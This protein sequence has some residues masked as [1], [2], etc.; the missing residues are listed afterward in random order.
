MRIIILFFLL[1]PFILYGQTFKYARDP[2]PVSLSPAEQIKFVV[3]GDF[4][5]AWVYEKKKLTLSVF[6]ENLNRI[7]KHDLHKKSKPVGESLFA[8]SEHGSYYVAI[9]EKGRT[10]LLNVMNN[11][12][13]KTVSHK[14]QDILYIGAYRDKIFLVEASE[15]ADKPMLRIQQL[16]TTLQI[17]HHVTVT[18]SAFRANTSFY[19][20]PVNDSIIIYAEAI[21]NLVNES[22]LKVNRI[23]I[24]NGQMEKKEFVASD[25][26][27]SSLRIE[28]DPDQNLY[29]INLVSLF[30]GTAAQNGKERTTYLVK[31][32]KDWTIGKS[33]SL[34]K[35]TTAIALSDMNVYNLH[36]FFLDRKLL[37]INQYSNGSINV[38][39][40]SLSNSRDAENW[41][42]AKELMK[43]MQNQ[44]QVRWHKLIASK[45]MSEWPS[46]FDPNLE[47]KIDAKNSFDHDK[48]NQ[49]HSYSGSGTGIELRSGTKFYE[50]VSIDTSLAKL[51]H[52]DL[53]G[54]QVYFQGKY[55]A[56][57]FSSIAPNKIEHAGLHPVFGVVN[58]HQHSLN[59]LYFYLTPL[60]V[61]KS[62]N[63]FL[64][65]Y[66]FKK[67]VFF[68]IMQLEE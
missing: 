60:M 67:K 1:L 26:E 18:P 48:D 7:A 2:L 15:S 41:Q 63:S 28:V 43:P 30:P 68:A 32:N 29:L 56:H 3:R 53:P 54:P 4:I 45:P 46:Q 42:R 24:R 12:N 5:H 34:D 47:S 13:V 21:S 19:F 25:S 38:M 27:F 9:P 52:W 40:N 55:M 50:F 44:E 57:G 64:L 49:S 39:N 59:P 36:S 66:L 31:I 37:L 10:L 17:Q 62:E 65:P 23:N 11:G 35:D 16:D 61:Q 58:T 51:S 8:L 14:F 22:R 6:N 33:L 20:K